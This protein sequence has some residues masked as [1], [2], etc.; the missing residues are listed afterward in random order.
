MAAWGFA[1]GRMP[2]Q[3]GHDDRGGDDLKG[4]VVEEDEFY[5]LFND[6]WLFQIPYSDSLRLG[7]GNLIARALADVAAD[8]D[9]EDLVSHVDLAFVHVV[10]H[11]LGTF[12][13]DFVVAAMAE[14]IGLA[15]VK[16]ELKRQFLIMLLKFGTD[17]ALIFK[18]FCY[19]CN[20]WFVMSNALFVT[21]IWG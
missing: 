1:L 7:I 20:C 19:L 14:E 5:G 12:S 3:V 9:D 6:F 11:R 16:G 15:G 17:N 18:Y 13:P 10:E 2:D 21:S 4:T 8:I